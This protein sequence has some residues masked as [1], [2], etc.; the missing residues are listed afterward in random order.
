MFRNLIPGLSDKYHLVAPDYPGYGNSSM[1]ALGEFDYTFD[2][3][4][5]IVEKLV[6]ELGID[7]Y[8]IY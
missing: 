7:A 3:M 8:S 1:P 2:R 5:E 6:D 4:A